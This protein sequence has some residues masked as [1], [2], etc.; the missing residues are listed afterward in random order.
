M[1]RAA[2]SLGTTEEHTRLSRTVDLANR[3]EDH[4]PIWAAE[5]GGGAETSDGVFVGVGVVDHDVCCVFGADFRGEVLWFMSL[6]FIEAKN[7]LTRGTYSMN[8]NRV[9]HVLRFDG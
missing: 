5:V 6:V 2:Q 9:I 3:F 7:G 1:Q 8:L 4:I